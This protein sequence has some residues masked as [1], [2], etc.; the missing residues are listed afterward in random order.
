M[1]PLVAES[2]S[3]YELIR[4]LGLRPTGS[5]NYRVRAI[6]KMYGLDVTHF[7]GGRANCGDGKVGGT[8]KMAWRDILV[9]NRTGRKEKASL[10]RRAL[11]ESGTPEMCYECGMGP[12]WQGKPLTLQVDHRNGD[13][14]DNRPGNPRFMC[15]NCHAQTPNFGS[16]NLPARAAIGPRTKKVRA[17]RKW[18]DGKRVTVRVYHGRVF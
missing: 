16:G 1:S 3:F 2:R 4:K 18:V 7:L 13:F 6:V 14:L 10:L 17:P 5:A 12:E 8:T 15:P 9:F 11:I